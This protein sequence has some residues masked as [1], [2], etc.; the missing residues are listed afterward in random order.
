M[1]GNSRELLLN[2]GSIFNNQVGGVFDYKSDALVLENAGGGGSFN[3]SGLVKKSGGTGNS[4]FGSLVLFNNTNGTVD[5]GTGAIL[6]Q[7]NG[8][9]N[10][11]FT[12]L[13]SKVLF[14]S[15]TH[16]FADGSV[17]NGVINFGGAT[18]NLGTTTINDTL[19]LTAGTVN[20]GGKTTTV[21]GVLNWTGGSTL[22]SGTL[23]LTAATV[24]NIDDTVAASFHTLSGVTVNNAGAVNYNVLAGNSREL[25][26]NSG[27]VFNNQAGGV[28]DFKSD[29]L[30]TQNAGGGG[31]FNNSGLVKKSGGTG[32][33]GFNSLVSFNNTSGTVDSGTGAIL[34]QTNG[35]HSGTFTT[36]GNKV[37]FNAA[38]HNFADGSVLNGT[39]NFSGALINFGNA[40]V[41]DTLNLTGGSLA[42]GTGKTATVDGVFNWTAGA[43]VFGPGTLSASAANVWNINDSVGAGFHVLSGLTVNNRGRV[44][45]Q[46]LAGNSRELL[47]NNGAAFNNLS[48]GTFDFQG[49]MAVLEN[50][51]C[52][53]CRFDNSGVVVKSAGSG[54][55]G[56]LGNVLA[57]SNGVG[58]VFRASSGTLQMRNFNVNDG[59][60]DTGTGARL[61]LTAGTLINNGTLSGSGAIDAS[62]VINNG[63]IA[64]ALGAPLTINGN[65]SLSPT[66]VVALD[67]NGTVRGVSHDAIDVNGN[68]I[69]GGSLQATRGS[70]FVPP[71]NSSYDVLRAS[72]VSGSFASST[73]PANFSTQLTATNV[74]L[75]FFSCAGSVCFDNDAG[76]FLWNNPLN[77]TGNALP[78]ASDDAV[79]DLGT[80]MTVVLDQGAFSAGSLLTSSDVLFSLTGG[81]LGLTRASTLNGDLNVRG[82]RFD[83]FGAL[84]VGGNVALSS[85]ALNFEAATTL[86]GNLTASGGSLSGAGNVSVARTFAWSGGALGGAG[87]TTVA[88][89]GRLLISGAAD[90][91][92]VGPRTLINNSANGS[93]WSGTGAVAAGGNAQGTASFINNGLLSIQT[94]AAWSDGSIVNNGTMTKSSAGGVQIFNA[95]SGR[96]DNAGVFNLTAGDLMLVGGGTQR[97]VFNLG[98]GRELILQAGSD[99]AHQQHFANGARLNGGLLSLVS[100]QVQLD[101][102]GSGLVIGPDTTLT[103]AGAT[104]GGPGNLTVNARATVRLVAGRLG[105]T[106][107]R[108]L[109]GALVWSG[110]EVADGSLLTNGTSTISSSAVKA[111]DNGTWINTGRVTLDDGALQLA[112]SDARIVNRAGGTFALAADLTG[113]GRFDNEVSAS[114]TKSTPGVTH[115]GVAFNNAGSIVI[116]AGAI[117]FD[118]D[119][120]NFGSIDLGRDGDSGIQAGDIAVLSNGVRGRIFG[121]G[122]ID[123]A[124]A[125]IAF[126][127]A[128]VMAP[129]HSPGTITIRGDFVQT[130]SGKLA[131]EIGGTRPGTDFD[132][133][134]ISGRATL[135]GA[136]ELDLLNNFLPP[137]GGSFD[138]VNSVSL[139]GDFQ[140]V[141]L[142]SGQVL[143]GAALSSVYQISAAALLAGS[144]P[145][146]QVIDD[147]LVMPS[148]DIGRASGTIVVNDGVG[149]PLIEFVPRRRASCN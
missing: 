84:T 8:T 86:R 73:L 16:N 49:D 11:T 67:I 126:T 31:S 104:V 135:A 125:G 93:S 98:G 27:S 106:G 54:S 70:G 61:A 68:L 22:A 96:F 130:A 118:R 30:V 15:G 23:A 43:T 5:S 109:N 60:I 107:T 28:F 88:S 32:N 2:S 17:L 26:M 64:P 44:N 121:S 102:S 35:T 145:L 123:V 58:G 34:L 105:G 69:L 91:L 62:D 120:T 89:A 20:L 39:F 129:G 103:L 122:F 127:N 14:N 143:K 124:N 101:G 53:P 57:V 141:I 66:S 4:G 37:L 51:G 115:V 95:E 132:L 75:N 42:I 94:A 116:S 146:Q 110:G 149:E 9:H 65:L 56:I 80:A 100:G 7:T 41:N 55:G 3:N 147:V 99:P 72:A 24:T 50:A 111:F 59:T 36:L 97:G 82:G 18:V 108:T 19:N 128:G 85:G 83:S 29:A 142:P 114:L 45:Y 137:A 113:A 78:V 74:N 48:G 92:F 148:I 47:I 117:R 112:G 6:L 134:D 76:D 144:A 81:S 119:F 25:L 138:V 46:V 133:L 136:I 13:G 40:T 90:K 10:G 140:S 12:A 52:N 63:T 38:T 33:S 71:Q 77:W 87:T 131:V 1:A 79:I 21:D 139:V